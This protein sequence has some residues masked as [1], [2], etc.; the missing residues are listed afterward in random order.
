RWLRV[1]DGAQGPRVTLDGREVLLLCSND[2]LGLAGHPAVRA[3]AAEGAE[4]WGAGAGASPLVSGHMRIH[5]E[6]ELELAE[7]KEQEACVLFGSG[8]LANLGVVSAL[9]GRGEVILSDELN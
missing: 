4:R 2:Y 5:R 9:A 3:A 8:F 1:I 6:L 7:F